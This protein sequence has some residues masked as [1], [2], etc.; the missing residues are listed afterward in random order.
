M[1]LIKSINYYLIDCTVHLHIAMRSTNHLILPSHRIWISI[2][3]KV[4]AIYHISTLRT[5]SIRL[6]DWWLCHQ[7]QHGTTLCR[8][9]L[10]MFYYQ[11]VTTSAPE[12]EESVRF[13]RWLVVECDNN[14]SAKKGPPGGSPQPSPL[15]QT[16]TDAFV[17]TSLDQEGQ[18]S[19]RIE[20]FSYSPTVPL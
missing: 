19:P 2:L 8:T 17:L 11:L 7:W 15:R 14:W 6:V 9:R 20:L 4:V 5:W 12:D 18:P 3:A 1:S 10:V 13:F 16:E